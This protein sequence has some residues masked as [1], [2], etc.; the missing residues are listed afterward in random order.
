MRA[1]G[2]AKVSDTGIPRVDVDREECLI[3][4]VFAFVWVVDTDE[5]TCKATAED[6][7]LEVVLEPVLDPTSKD[8]DDREFDWFKSAFDGLGVVK[9]FTV[10]VGQEV[11]HRSGID[12]KPVVKLVDEKGE[13]VSADRFTGFV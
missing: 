4:F 9:T 11:D 13:R 3:R 2:I 5:T 1:I 6:L 7:C 12:T 10:D 8:V